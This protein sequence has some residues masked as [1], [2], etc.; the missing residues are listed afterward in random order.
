MAN[1]QK[2]IHSVFTSM[3]CFGSFLFIWTSKGTADNLNAVIISEIQI[4]GQSVSDEFLELYN[5]TTEDIDLEGWDIKK[6]T[7]TGTLG[8]VATNLT[9]KIPALGFFLI[10]PRANCGEAKDESCYKGDMAPDGFYTTNNLLAKDNSL[11]I[12]DGADNLIDLA[13]WG[14]ASDFKGEVFDANPEGGQSL[15]RK[16]EGALFSDS[17]S[18]KNDFVIQGSPDPQNSKMLAGGAN[19]FENSAPEDGGGSAEEENNSA[20]GQEDNAEEDSSQDNADLP[21]PE[22]EILSKI[23][24]TEFLP[25]PEDSDKDNEFIEIYNN[26]DGDEDLEGWSIED[27]SGKTAVFIIPAK[28]IIKKGAYKEFYSDETKISLNNTGDGVILKNTLGTVISETPVCDAATEKA[29]FSLDENNIWKWTKRPTPGRE[30]IIIYDE[31]KIEET[32]KKGSVPK[33]DEGKVKGEE[34]LSE[35]AADY[36]YSDGIMITEIFPNP[37][38]MDNKLSYEWIEI[39]N[40]GEKDINLKGW[41]ID[42]ILKKGSKAYVVGE[43]RMIKKGTSL[44]FSS[45]ETKIAF[46]NSEDEVNLLWP[47]GTAVDSVQYAKTKEGFSYALADDGKWAWTSALTPGK[48][49]IFENDD[50]NLQNAVEI[51]A[52][53][54]EAAADPQDISESI[55]E[56]D[57]EKAAEN[58]EIVYEGT[59]I[60]SAKKMPRFSNV[61]ISG[62]VSTPPGVFSDDSFYIFGSGIQIY[63]YTAN[64][65][66][67]DIGDK[68]EASGAISQVGGEKRLLVG[69]IGDIKVLSHDNLL[70]PKLIAT[71]DVGENFEGY[72]V[73]VEGKISG[74][75]S[76]VFYVDDGSGQ[77]KVYIKPKTGIAKPEMKVDDPVVITGEVSRTS[78]GYRILPR[79]R[80]D[81]RISRTS[82]ISSEEDPPEGQLQKEE[83]QSETK[84]GVVPIYKY[85]FAIAGLLIL[86]DW[87]RL[88]IKNN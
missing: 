64:F 33:E 58:S 13:G 71:G 50:K 56:A 32:A 27:K 11:L 85:F 23:I 88:K 26:G 78:M 60:E 84:E 48:K 77:V 19:D 66:G 1:R 73:A 39:Y 34:I 87:G 9:G 18:N 70:E 44:V 24:L 42:D 81:I 80:G 31:P 22:A 67:I 21:A 12:F 46:N 5:P 41:Q 36:D 68:I 61:K 20:A 35:T 51:K 55:Q 30:N 16:R 59:G 45:E 4:S 65:S 74:F 8:N 52:P 37:A 28:T 49:N 10:A 6:K 40:N 47:D 54:K 29:S 62:I 38:G 7:K 25:D 2:I 57:D 82:G 63:S 3:V 79:F 14:E 75:G 83:M 76:D 69:G 86:A 53:E 17:G 43:D 72:L 15:G